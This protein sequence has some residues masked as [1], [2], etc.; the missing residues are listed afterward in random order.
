MQVPKPHRSSGGVDHQQNAAVGERSSTG[1]HHFF[2]GRLPPA[3]K[4]LGPG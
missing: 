3:P 2:S 4:V 1:S